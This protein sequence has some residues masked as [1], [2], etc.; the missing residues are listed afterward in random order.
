M[1]RLFTPKAAAEEVVVE[2]LCPGALR[3]SRVTKLMFAFS[4]KH[5]NRQFSSSLKEIVRGGSRLTCPKCD[6]T[7]EYSMADILEA[8]T[9]ELRFPATTAA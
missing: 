7:Y 5:C 1:A 2:P 4:C 8:A 9:E 6:R 3:K